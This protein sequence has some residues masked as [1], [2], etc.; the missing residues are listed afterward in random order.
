[1]INFEDEILKID[2]KLEKANAS[3]ASMQ[4]QKQSEHYEK[5]KDT[6]KEANETKVSTR[7]LF[8]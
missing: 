3:L 4:A 8:K 6:I 1:M 7:S 5:V 2:K